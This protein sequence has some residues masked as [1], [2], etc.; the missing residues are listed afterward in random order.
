M[1]EILAEDKPD[2][3][4]DF[5]F[6]QEAVVTTYGDGYEKSNG[7]RKDFLINELSALENS[8][9]T[10]P[11][12]HGIMRQ[13]VVSKGIITCKDCTLAT[14]VMDPVEQINYPTALLKI[15]CP[16]LRDC[17]WIG[18]LCEAET[19]L[20]VCGRF[21][22]LCPYECGAVIKRC[23]NIKHTEENCPLR[24][25]PCQF[26]KIEFIY[27]FTDRHMEECSFKPIKCD[28]GDD[29]SRAKLALHIRTECPLVEVE[30]PY[31]KYSCKIGNMH[32]KDLLAHKKEFYI[33]HQ[34]MLEEENKRMKNNVHSI[35]IRVNLKRNI[36]F[37][38]WKIPNMLI[39]NEEIEG[40]IICIDSNK[41]KCILSTI[42]PL[43]IGIKKF[44]SSRS[45]DQQITRY[46]LRLSTEDD[47]ESY[48]IEISVANKDVGNTVYAIF[49]LRKEIY[50][51]YI[52]GDNNIVVRIFFNTE[53]RNE[54]IIFS[55][56]Y[57]N[58]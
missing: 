18:M 33:E 50:S 55:G 36:D 23:E 34:D 57:V 45:G 5:L 56:L 17:T 6:I 42:N 21:K 13:A 41:F 27:K 31:A 58:I 39:L 32:R 48:S 52:Q 38:E 43:S 29:F 53:D 49:T 14:Y 12:C 37:V 2:L 28:C 20:A 1:A 40:P 7:F 11:N 44:Q 4:T 47:L 10:C 16:L 30:C 8:I 9:I 54:H 3:M 15:K 19:H 26:C 35:E 51:K 22:I 24:S 25:V 46:Q